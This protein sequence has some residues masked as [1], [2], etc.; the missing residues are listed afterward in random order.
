MLVGADPLGREPLG[1]FRDAGFDPNL[2]L[3]ASRTALAVWAKRP[4][5][6]SDL[7]LYILSRLSPVP[8]PI[9][10]QAE[11]SAWLDSSKRPRGR[12]KSD[13]NSMRNELILKNYP[14]YLSDERAARKR[15][16]SAEKRAMPKADRADAA[17]NLVAARRVADELERAGL[18]SISPAHVQKIYSSAKKNHI[19]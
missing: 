9:K 18:G 1:T 17:P 16:T 11:L 4:P 12:P 19:S 8:P 7:G 6:R 3:P 14:K 13:P 15:L 5:V 2:I 10:L